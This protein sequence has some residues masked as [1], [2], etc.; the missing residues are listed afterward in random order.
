MGKNLV[1][2]IMP[3]YNWEKYLLEQLM[4]IY[5]Q[6]YTNRYLIFINDW[7]TDSSEKIVWDFV[8]HYNLQDKVKII[9]KKNWWVNSAVNRWLLEVRNV[10]DIDNID[11]F[12][13]YCDADDIWTREKLSTQ[14]EYM[15]KHPECWLSYHDLVIIN[16]NS[17]IKAPSMLKPVYYKWESFFAIACFWVHFYSTQ[18][19][20]KI[21]HI[22]DVY[23]LPIWFTIWQDLWTGMAL[24]IMNVNI[25][26]IDKQ[27]GYYRRGHTSLSN[28]SAEIEKAKQR[29][30][31]MKLVLKKNPNIN[32]QYECNYYEDRYI[33]R[34]KK[35]YTRIRV[36]ILLLIKY[37]RIFF[38]YL[39]S[40]FYEKILSKLI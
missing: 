23:P 1:Y 16:E 10:Y 34:N 25:W 22:D 24:S 3:C 4:S 35:W 11:S 19:M 36:R 7:S 12:I 39:K 33:K 18:M 17:V 26:Y 28:K 15:I 32:I 31:Y 40:F 29:I 5:Y 13:S 21:K 20:F 37:P 38:I 9:T 2:I 27:L 8:S 6:T 14:V 30:E